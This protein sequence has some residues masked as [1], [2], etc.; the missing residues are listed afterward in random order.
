MSV[1]ISLNMEMST[2]AV[3]LCEKNW[4][5]SLKGPRWNVDWYVEK[6]DAMGNAQKGPY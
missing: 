2:P 1:R 5:L 4:L 3:E 6:W